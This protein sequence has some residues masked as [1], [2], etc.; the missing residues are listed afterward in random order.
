MNH[1]PLCGGSWLDRYRIEHLSTTPTPAPRPLGRMLRI[2]VLTVLVLTGCL[3]AVVSVA[4]VKLWPTVRTWTEALLSG[5]ETALT[6]QVRQLAGRLGDPRLMDLTRSGVESFA[7][8]ALV[9]NPGFERLLNSVAAVPNLGP[10]VQNGAYLEVLQEA[11]RQNVQNLADLN[12]D[13]IDS[14][15]IR[16]ATSQVQE[17]LRL[18]PGVGAAAG[19]VDPLVLKVLGSQAFQQ[20]SRSG[21]LERL[22]GSAERD[23]QVD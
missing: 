13:K 22:F 3:I 8:S 16:V 15:E 11:S 5:K 1:C 21:V 2:A 14:P 9:G 17:A 7:L 6:S 19:F 4:A 10:L 12:L 18:S 20:L 23:A